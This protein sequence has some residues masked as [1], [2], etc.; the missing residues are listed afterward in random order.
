MDNLRLLYELVNK[1]A[2]RQDYSNEYLTLLNSIV[3][4]GVPRVITLNLVFQI[5][6]HHHFNIEMFNANNHA[7]FETTGDVQ[8]FL[9]NDNFSFEED[10]LD[11]IEK[12]TKMGYF[13]N[14]EVNP[15]WY[16]QNP[17]VGTMT[18]FG[19]RGRI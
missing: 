13:I 16:S 19:Y 3:V 14:F 1:Y 5:I 8:K 18:R 2:L 6:D 9:N 7:L 12:Y 11:F 10:Y 4:D 15:E 17:S